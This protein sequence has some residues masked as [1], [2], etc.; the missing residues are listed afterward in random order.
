MIKIY[1]YVLCWGGLEVPVIT[2]PEHVS[3]QRLP[4]LIYGGLTPPTYTVMFRLVPNTSPYSGF[5]PH[6][7]GAHPTHLHSYVQTSP[8]Q[9]YVQRLP[10]LIYRGFTPT[11]YTAP[12]SGGNRASRCHNNQFVLDWS[13]LQAHEIISILIFI[14]KKSLKTPTCGASHATD[15]LAQHFVCVANRLKWR[16]I[17]HLKLA[18]G[19]YLQTQIRRKVQQICGSGKKCVAFNSVVR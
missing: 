11:T 12:Q 15:F 7:R 8:E 3:V 18:R 5:L 10:G 1:T 4:G 17:R 19:N 13:L 6:L 14:I 16:G 2:G 9:V